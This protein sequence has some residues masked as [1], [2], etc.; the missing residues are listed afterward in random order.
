MS[1]ILKMKIKTII[2]RIKSIAHRAG[3]GGQPLP[4]ENWHKKEISCFLASPTQV[5]DPL[6]EFRNNHIILVS[7]WHL[8]GVDDPFAFAHRCW[9]SSPDLITKNLILTW[10]A[11]VV[12]L[13]VVSINPAVHE[14]WIR[15]IHRTN[16]SSHTVLM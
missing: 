14:K 12:D 1:G 15:H 10:Y 8:H 2:T 11:S 13:H 16:I 6:L 4:C 7:S 3:E 9:G 5:L